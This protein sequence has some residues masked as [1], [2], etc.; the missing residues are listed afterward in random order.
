MFVYLV[1]RITACL[2]PVCLF[3]F[4]CYICINV[5]MSVCLYSHMYVCKNKFIFICFYVFIYICI[6]IY[7]C[8]QMYVCMSECEYVCMSILHHYES[9]PLQ[10]TT[11]KQWIKKDFLIESLVNNT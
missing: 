4:F 3:V 5:C 11:I 1:Y 6:I 2:M 9:L 7:V 8:L 10:L